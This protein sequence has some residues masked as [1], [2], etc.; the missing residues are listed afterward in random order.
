MLLYIHVPFC[1]TKCAYCAFASQ[2]YIEESVSVYLRLVQQELEIRSRQLRRRKVSSIY[3]GGGTPTVLPFASMSRIVDAVYKHFDPVPGC[4]FTLEANPENILEMADLQAFSSM[5]VNRISLGV[6][7][8]DDRLLYTL[9]RGHDSRQAIKAARKIRQAD[10]A[11][12]SLDL[13]WSLPGQT[14]QGWM[15]E[16]AHAVQ[17]A[18]DHLSCYGLS[19]EPGTRLS[20][21]IQSGELKLPDERTQTGMYV[22]GAHYLE[23]CGFLQYEISN[24]ARMGFRC[25]HN[26]GYWAGESFLGAG[27]SSVSTMDGLRWQNPSAICD[28]QALGEKN[29]SDLEFERLSHSRKINELVMLSLRTSR[30]LNLKDYKQLKGECFS[31]RYAGV[32]QALHQNSLIRMAHGYLSLTRNGMLVSDSILEKFME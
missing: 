3:I 22:H 20:A 24:F 8:L 15:A 26:L 11:A 28:Y 13:I 29:F 1:R 21:G 9:Q 30:G 27:P 17:L 14:L 25:K 10:F 16:L 32:I 7:S 6:Q 5:G 12:L 18:P 23:S 2:E 19:L 4:E 31:R